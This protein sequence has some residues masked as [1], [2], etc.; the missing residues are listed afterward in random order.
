[1]KRTLFIAGCAI[2][3][4]SSTFASTDTTEPFGMSFEE[5]SLVGALAGW[6]QPATAGVPALLLAEKGSDD[7]GDHDSGDDHGGDHDGNDDHGGD[8]DS[9]DDSDDSDGDDSGRDKP[10]IPG[11]SGCDDAGD[12]AEH[13]ECQG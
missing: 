2:V 11:G 12:I 7:G 9:N 3:L 8:H 13:A 6:T 5:F 4:G 1:M 10:R